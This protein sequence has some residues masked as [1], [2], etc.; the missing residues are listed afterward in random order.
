MGV[1]PYKRKSWQNLSSKSAAALHRQ[2]CHK[3]YAGPMQDM[4]AL[5]PLLTFEATVCSAWSGS[6]SCSQRLLFA[7]SQLEVCDADQLKDG[8]E[9]ATCARICSI[10]ELKGNGDEV[11]G[12]LNYG[13]QFMFIVM[14]SESE[15]RG[16]FTGTFLMMD[17]YTMQTGGPVILD[18]YTKVKFSSAPIKEP[19]PKIVML[20]YIGGG[21]LGRKAWL[22]AACK[23]KPSTY[24]TIDEA[25]T[26]L[27][28]SLY[29][30]HLW[31]WKK[32]LPVLVRLKILPR[33]E[34]SFSN[35]LRKEI[36]IIRKECDGQLKKIL[37]E[38]K[39]QILSQRGAKRNKLRL[40][41]IK[42]EH[43]P[44]SILHSIKNVLGCT[45]ELK[46]SYSYEQLETHTFT[47]LSTEFVA[48]KVDVDALRGYSSTTPALKPL[49]RPSIESTSL[50]PNAH[51]LCGVV[52]L[53]GGQVLVLVEAIGQASHHMAK[54]PVRSFKR[55]HDLWAFDEALRIL[56][57]YDKNA[58]CIQF[59]RFDERYEGSE[60][61]GDVQLC[62]YVGVTN[63]SWIGLTPGRRE[64]VL[65]DDENRLRMC[66][67]A[68]LMM[69]PRH[70]ILPAQ[71]IKASIYS[72]RETGTGEILNENGSNS[73][74]ESISAS[75]YLLDDSFT[76]LKCLPLNSINREN[77]RDF[78]VECKDFG[79]KLHLVILCSGVHNY[80]LLSYIIEVSSPQQK[81]TS[82][83][84]YE[85]SRV[86]GIPRNET[87]VALEY[88]FH[89]F[90]KYAIS[91]PL[92]PENRY[93]SLVFLLSPPC[94]NWENNEAKRN[95]E[96]LVKSFIRNIEEK[97][98]VFE[99]LNLELMFNVLEGDRPF[100]LSL[101]ARKQS[102]AGWIQKLLSLVPVQIARAENNML[103]LMIDGLEIPSKVVYSDAVSLASVLHFGTYDLLLESWKGEVKVISSMGKQSSGKSY[104]LNHLAGSLLDVAGGRCMDDMT[105]R[106][107]SKCMYV[108]L[109]F[110][111]LGSFERN[112]QEDMLLSTL[113]A[114]TSNI[115]IFNK[116][117]FHMDKETEAIFQRF[118]HGV[119]LVK[120][121]DKLFKDVE[122]LKLEF[123]EKI[124]SMC[125]R[126]TQCIREIE[127]RYKS[128]R[129]FLQD[130]KLVLSQISAQDWSSVDS[131]RVMMRIS[132]LRSHLASAIT[133]GQCNGGEMLSD[134][135][136]DDSIND[137]PIY[138]KSE[139]CGNVQLEDSGLQLAVCGTG[140]RMSSMNDIVESLRL[141]FQAAFPR[142]D[143][144]DTEWHA[145][146]QCFLSSLLERR[147]NRV[148]EW[149][150]VNTKE[151]EDADIQQL[152]LEATT[153]LLEL[154]NKVLLCT[155]R[156]SK[157]FLTCVLL[158]GY[159]SD[160]SCLGTH[161]CSQECSFC[162][163][164]QGMC[165]TGEAE[166]VVMECTDVAGHG[167][168][169]D[170]NQRMHTCQ[171]NCIQYELASNCNRKCSLR[172]NHLGEHYCQ[173][174]A[175]EKCSLPG[176]ENACIMPFDL[177]EH[178][179]HLCH[180]QFCSMQCSMP[181][182]MRQ[183]ATKNHF[184]ELEADAQHFCGYEHPCTSMCEAHGVCNV[185]TELL[186][187][188]RLFHGK[189]GDFEYDFVSE[190][191]EDRKVCCLMIPPFTRNHSGSHVHSTNT[192]VVHY[193]DAR[194]PDCDYYCQLPFGHGGSHNTVHGN[195]KKTKFV[196]EMEDI[197][198]QDRKYVRGETGVAEMCTMHCRSRGRGHTH[199][200][201]C[202][203]TEGDGCCTGKLYD[204]A[205]HLSK[206]KC[207][208]LG[209][210]KPLDEMTHG[211]Y[212]EYIS[213]IDPCD[214]DEKELFALCNHFCLSEEHEAGTTERSYCTEKLW[215]DPVPKAAATQS[216][217]GGY[218]T[219]DGHHFS[220]DHTKIAPHNV[221]FVMD[222]SGSM[223]S[224]D[225]VPTMAMFHRSRLGCVYEAVL[226]FIRMR[227][228]A[229]AH[230]G[231]HVEDTISVVLF[232]TVG[233][234]CV[235][236]V[237]IA[238]SVVDNLLV[239]EADGATT[240]SS[241]LEK[242]ERILDDSLG[243]PQ[244]N[245]KA[246]VIIF[247]SD[248]GN[249]GGIDPVY[250]VHKMRMKDPRL[251]VHTIMFG[252]DP[253][254]KIL[255]DMA[256]AGNGTYQLS[257][258]EVQLARSFEDL[259]KSLQPKLV[260]LCHC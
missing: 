241:G 253:A 78:H 28:V 98:K 111:G 220:C 184:H 25:T 221:I 187:Q 254:A 49:P 145:S 213:F 57:L 257:L 212:W 8:K 23:I 211:T 71:L 101:S 244:L 237:P 109:D 26:S 103:R 259:A 177:G 138:L 178:K 215:H 223:A 216:G 249:N 66:D 227:M 53:K 150:K 142:V 75:V 255:R 246:P 173:T 155:C 100:K 224:K 207:E 7:G 176:C 194:C 154:K 108:I 110:E 209:V 159:H 203:E 20:K 166:F 81:C 19:A 87:L 92:C 1:E 48:N 15:N 11:R 104:L 247:L 251:I 52:F 169:H 140:E 124:H 240:Y 156:C 158:K 70:I 67:F 151:L 102:I 228:Q 18:G 37:S 38:L 133:L 96:C 185:V 153:R 99:K 27:C 162:Q 131:R 126:T 206:E 17:D 141:K 160:H 179:R 149:L 198:L 243:N 10:V 120:A 33:I 217:A 210:K 202:P 201:P 181:G 105:V 123:Y 47:W 16:P 22:K 68:R 117:D 54:S 119:T 132:I 219:E 130:F 235:Q 55:G 32:E 238:E 122:D 199:L 50:D 39:S 56:A 190:Q 65:V 80:A 165:F 236:S 2:R 258:D 91:P 167:G 83:E 34:K 171:Q 112:D 127:S 192:N 245:S 93:L 29:K 147:Q 196:A 85:S 230:S 84:V 136:N 163:E 164:E 51:R 144:S 252:T 116:K 58:R 76:L 43:A 40:N 113:S 89:A 200:I 183:C 115:T 195:M 62:D 137:D 90:D 77:T 106:W 146:Y 175:S 256:V 248:G 174:R 6:D 107:D 60:R 97:G 242:A 14:V 193:C 30:D 148:L 229:T 35:L 69:R 114:A 139:I 45:S 36:E 197:D 225:I 157:C 186:K 94:H 24:D 180:E 9:C 5:N 161:I 59:F 86:H 205:R 64:I 13:Q 82:A 260:A 12:P 63:V 88:I 134:L 129:C 152:I 46:L 250:K 72:S 182:C 4:N 121:D 226:R 73:L 128:G 232:D 234:L 61:I 135:D 191:S 189:R 208:L 233:E 170:C 31:L 3:D 172:V 143:H 118:Q 21:D 168:N 42:L 41:L 231:L 79:P 74:S 218:I 222:K 214:E 125:N 188:T 95:C 239:Y 204:G 44:K